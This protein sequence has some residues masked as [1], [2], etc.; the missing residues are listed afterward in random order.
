EH[1]R[2]A[3]P[4]RRH[5][6]PPQARLAVD[7]RL[8]AG[9]P[10]V[11]AE[12]GQGRRPAQPGLLR[13]QRAHRL[14]R[15]E[16]VVRAGAVPRPRVRLR[17]G[18]EVPAHGAAHPGRRRA[19]HP[20]HLRRGHLRRSE[21]D[22]RLRPAAPGALRPGR[23][24]P[25]ARR[26]LHHP[27]GHL[28]VR[29][30]GR[31][32]LR[33]VDD[34]H[35]RLLPAAPQGL[36]A[37]RQRRRRQP[38]GPRRP[39]GRPAGAGDPRRDAPTRDG[40]DLHPPDRAR[41]PRRRADHGQPDPEQQRARSDPRGHPALRDL[42]HLAPL[43][44]HLRLVHRLRLRV[45][46]GPAGP[47][48]GAV[49][50]A[51]PGRGADLPRAAARLAHPA[52]RRRPRRPVPGLGGDLLELRGHGRRGRRRA[53]G[54]PAGFA[55]A[56]PGRLRDALRVQR[57]RERVGVQ[58]DPRD[59]HRQGPDVDRA[60]GGGRRPRRPAGDQALGCPD[61]AGRGGRRLR[62]RAGEPGLPAVVPHPRQRRRG[63]PHLHR[64]LRP[65]L[66]RHLGG[67]HPAARRPAPP[68]L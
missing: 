23:G 22:D 48:P 50:G 46:A 19:A 56:V 3:G 15:L 5:P 38:R 27:A 8:A 49:P 20:L 42:G 47:V 59:L 57:H 65:L 54:L 29:R 43:H 1:P 6:R 13:A 60:R 45:R 68:G 41:R 52:R 39:A 63:L 53:A 2:R 21:L 33:L 37:R 55:A 51:G 7:R 40:G 9:G 31:R 67:V 64:L 28:V 18:P 11:L 32:Q 44:R 66:R 61:R 4:E 62:R 36:G 30:R 10:R 12:H 58:D 14:L 17:P 25:R 16:P 26:L 35:Q 34:Q 24:V